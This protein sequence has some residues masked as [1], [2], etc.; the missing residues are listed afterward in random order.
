MGSLTFIKSGLMTTVQDGGRQGHAFHAVPP[1]G[2]MDKA[3]AELAHA[4]LFRDKDSAL[5]ECTLIGPTMEFHSEVE[6]V[7]T[8]AD[9]R[10]QLDGK[11]IS[12]NSLTYA[13]ENSVLT[14]AAAI[15]GFRSYIGINGDLQLDKN[16]TSSAMYQYAGLGH[17]GGR[18]FK[19]GDMLTWGKCPKIDQQVRLKHKPLLLDSL[20]IVPGPEYNWLSD[21]SKQ[22]LVNSEFV[23]SP[24]SNRMGSKLRGPFLRT[25]S[26]LD[27]SLPVLPGFIQLPPDGQPI[28]ILQDGQTTGGY[29]RIAYMQE[30]ELSR[31]NQVRLGGSLNFHLADD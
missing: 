23:I 28:V 18:A 14:S 31:F 9:M 13:Q 29:P 16:L 25:D 27:H 15:H 24:D 11:P 19:K 8:G 30:A 17:Q 5:I 3:A 1:S 20:K 26:Q 22:L 12:L 2:F 10:W 7:I 21:E 6:F 4:V